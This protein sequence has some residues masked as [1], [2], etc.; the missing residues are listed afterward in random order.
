MNKDGVNV[1][2]R[3][4]LYEE[5]WSSPVTHVAKTYGVSDVAIH[6]ICKSMNI[7]TPPNGYWAKLKFGK[8]VTKEPLPPEQNGQNIKLGMK[9]NNS[10]NNA[11]G[12]DD[13]LEFLSI[14]EQAKLFGIASSLIINT[15]KKLCNEIREHKNIVTA[16]NIS[17]AS[18]EGTSY[19][20]SEYIYHR[21]YENNKNI[22]VP[23][24]AGCLSKEG[25]IRAYKILDTLIIGIK[26]LGY[27]VNNDMSFCI[28]G[29]KVEYALYES[30]GKK[31]HIITTKEDKAVQNYERNRWAKKPIIPIYDYCFNGK[32]T[33]C[34]KK[35]TYIR[36]TDKCI[37]EDRLP[38][39]LIQ[40][41]QQSEIVRKERLEHEEAQRK[42]EDEKRQRELFIETYNNEVDKLTLLVKE[43]NDFE[44][45][46]KIRD[47]VFYTQQKDFRHKKAEWIKWA[48]EKA[49][50]Y[51]PTI[52]KPDN[53]FGQRDYG[54][55]PIPK[56]KG[57]SYFW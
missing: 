38:D 26:L 54:A 24:L 16:W 28:R 31:K 14:E 39:M 51:D 48:K 8:E 43:A 18:I 29:E 50:W 40:L 23:I 53:I 9:L 20:Y 13:Y 47:Y 2:E 35:N 56:K 27:S 41:V 6:K 37:I 10:N 4:K 49:D 33:F 3:N 52:D 12:I 15:N 46:T 7:P 45:A 57:R 21:K 42:R 32:L 55:D 25:L 44:I 22:G 11:A 1:Y 17:H 19:S 36:D 34:T 30:Q 5:V